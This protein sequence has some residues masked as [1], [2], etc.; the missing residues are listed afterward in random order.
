MEKLYKTSRNYL[1]LGLVL[2]VFYREFT[3]FNDYT[4]F[5]QLAVLHTH[6]L[7]LG[8]FFFLIL[9]ILEKLFQLSEAS[10]FKLFYGVYNAGLGLTL[11]LMLIHGV[12]TVLGKESGA[13]ISGIAGLG[14]ILLTAGFLLFFSVLHERI[15][16]VHF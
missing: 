9:V 11:L 6:A 1:I 14:H 3:K 15:K 5:T 10:R 2:G 8:M 7:V 13:A 12:L 4:D 16:A